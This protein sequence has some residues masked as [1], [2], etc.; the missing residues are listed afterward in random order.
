MQL[1]ENRETGKRHLPG[2]EHTTACG[3][4]LIQ[5]CKENAHWIEDTWLDDYPEDFG[6]MAEDCDKCAKK[7]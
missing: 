5:D 3:A 4:S 6:D 1:I 2:D 7:L